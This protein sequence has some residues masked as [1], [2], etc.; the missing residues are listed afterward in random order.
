MN[1]TVFYTIP[2]SIFV[3]L[4]VINTGHALNKKILDVQKNQ[5]KIDL[6]Y[7]DRFP[8]K[9]YYNGIKIP[10]CTRAPARKG[11][12][13]GYVLLCKEHI[14]LLR[15]ASVIKLWKHQ[16]R[17]KGYIPFSMKEF[18]IINVHAHITGVK[19]YTPVIKNTITPDSNHVTGKFIRYAPE[20]N[21]YTVKDKQ[22]NMTSTV[23]ATPNHPFYVKNK[24][25]F[26]PISEVLSSDSLVTLSNHEA[27]LIHSNSNNLLLKTNNK[28]NKL[29]RVYN[30]E[31]EKKHVYFISNLN[32]LVH[33]P[34]K[35]LHDYYL[36]LKEN[37]IVK[38]YSSGDDSSVEISII[39]HKIKYLSGS[40]DSELMQNYEVL[41]PSGH[42]D[43]E[44]LEKIYRLGFSMQR[45][46]VKLSLEEASRVDMF[47]FDPD[48]IITFRLSESM[49]MEEYE[50][51]PLVKM[52]DYYAQL[53]DYTV[54]S[55]GTNILEDKSC[56]VNGTVSKGKDIL[57]GLNMKGLTILKQE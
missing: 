14:A 50:A 48:A 26:V 27:H 57:Q 9:K 54:S 51:G 7:Y 44:I 53:S 1:K 35:V 37:G 31:I 5:E 52:P 16:Q 45:E 36:F 39:R 55:T 18:G 46:Y 42:L 33:N 12:K 13:T 6:I 21:R 20:V 23:D 29:T 56:K 43:P 8:Y 19:E 15:P 22:T 4:L 10:E 40:S 41:T 32:L 49:P 47:T 28:K 38:K 17:L 11:Q 25:A 24:H 3:F 34:C 30:I 2:G